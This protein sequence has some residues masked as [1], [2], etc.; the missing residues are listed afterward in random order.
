LGSADGVTLTG[1]QFVT[2]ENAKA[3]IQFQEQGVR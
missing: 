1:P 3:I 2:Q